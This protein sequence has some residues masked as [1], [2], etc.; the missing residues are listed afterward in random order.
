MRCGPSIISMRC[1]T[2][3]PGS[4]Y[5]WHSHPFF[6]FSFVDD[7]AAVIGYPPGKRDV[8]RN[9][10]LFYHRGE[11][12]GAWCEGRQRPRFWVVHFTLDAAGL[13]RFTALATGDAS[14]RVWGLKPD[15]AAAFKSV[16]LHLLTEHTNRRENASLAESAWLQVLLVS[17]QRWATDTRE[18]GVL[19]EVT[20]PDLLKLWHLVNASVANPADFRRQIEA[21]PNYDSLRHGFKKTFGRSPHELMRQLRIQHVKNLLLETRLSIKEIALLCGYERQHELARA[22]RLT[23]GVAPTAWREHPLEGDSIR[24]Q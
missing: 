16:F 17:I 9:T 13:E 15:Q 4:V 12:H 19:P 2:G 14:R 21:L 1:L 7:D 11:R 23:T 20:N 6:E 24:A 5:G 10:L 22:F 8:E 3:E 18:P